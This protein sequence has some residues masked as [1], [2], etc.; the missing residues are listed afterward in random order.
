MVN[1]YAKYQDM[2]YI[3]CEIKGGILKI[4]A[5]HFHDYISNTFDARMIELLKSPN[6][7]PQQLAALKFIDN[8]RKN[9]DLFQ[10]ATTLDIIEN[11][12]KIIGTI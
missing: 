12:F 11:S 6:H 4:S 2:Y 10:R 1:G 3:I 7:I 9:Y 5:E 8:E